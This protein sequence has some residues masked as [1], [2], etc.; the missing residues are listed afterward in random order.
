MSARLFSTL[1]GAVMA[2]T[3]VL[4]FLLANDDDPSASSQA[5]PT[6]NPTASQAPGLQ[7]QDPAIGEVP[8][9]QWNAMKAAGMIRPGC[10]VT[11]REQLRRVELDYR[12]FNGD[13]KRGHLI[14]RADIAESVVRI[15]T[16]LL[17]ANFPIRRM[18]SVE[19]YGGDVKASLRADNTSAFNCRR[20][21]QINAP[22]L[23]S[24]HANGRAIDINPRENPWMDLRCKCWVPGPRLAPRIEGPGKIL[25]GGVVWKAFTSESWIWQNIK[26]PDYMHFDTGYP[27]KRYG[28]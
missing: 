8:L 24:P 26:V 17:E 16:K 23:K 5:Q 14:V 7:P 18:E 1:I 9:D 28:R 15:F 4:S 2:L 22:T 13:L 20:P 25:K 21:D 19:K 3:V 10:P 12:A 27:S 11:R 6:K